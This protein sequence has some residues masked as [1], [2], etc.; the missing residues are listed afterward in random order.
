MHASIDSI[1]FEVDDDD[2]VAASFVSSL[3]T[4]LLALATGFAAEAA[5]FG[6][7]FVAFAMIVS[8]GFNRIRLMRSIEL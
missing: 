5:F 2:D 6:D 1:I 7:A 4:F 8:V 3:S